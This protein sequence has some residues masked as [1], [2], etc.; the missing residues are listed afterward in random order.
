LTLSG[1]FSDWVR[2]LSAEKGLSGK[3]IQAYVADVKPFLVSVSAHGDDTA[4][5]TRDAHEAWFSSRAPCAG[6]TTARR[7]S[8]VK[9]FLA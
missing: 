8:S 3:T 9:S 6:S 5:L 1:A 4:S 2:H 7:R